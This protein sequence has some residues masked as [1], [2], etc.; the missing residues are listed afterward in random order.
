MK[1]A[2]SETRILVTFCLIMYSIM[3]NLYLGNTLQP[4]TFTRLF[5]F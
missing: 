1:D 4:P 5:E 3:V 2:F